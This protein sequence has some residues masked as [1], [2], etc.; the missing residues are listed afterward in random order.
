MPSKSERT[1]EQQKAGF[2][3]FSFSDEAW[4]TLDGYEIL[5]N[6]R[7]KSAEKRETYL[8]KGLH[9]EKLVLLFPEKKNCGTD[10][11]QRNCQQ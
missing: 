4:F 3:N 1:E 2:T 10:I 9:P 11:P 8:D 6:Y 5:Q 7:V